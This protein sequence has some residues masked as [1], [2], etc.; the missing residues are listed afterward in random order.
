MLCYW[1]LDGAGWVELKHWRPC[2]ALLLVCPRSLRLRSSSF[3]LV[4][5]GLASQ[6]RPSPP[7]TLSTPVRPCSR[8]GLPIRLFT[9]YRLLLPQTILSSH[10][11]LENHWE[12]PN[13]IDLAD[14]KLPRLQ[15]T[16]ASP[17]RVHWKL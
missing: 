4:Q 8:W 13:Q 11:A 14:Q 17:F 7:R 12:S 1:W 15:T 3:A 6:E 2:S 5:T 9:P 10:L 16:L